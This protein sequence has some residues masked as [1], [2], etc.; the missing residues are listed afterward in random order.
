MKYAWIQKHRDLFPITT[1]CRVLEVSKSGF[2]KSLTAKPSKRALRTMRITD[3]VKRVFEDSDGI[4]GSYKVASSMN[5]GE[6]LENACRNTV[7]KIMRDLG[8]KIRVTKRFKPRTTVVDGLKKPAKNI[9][10]QNFV[11]SEP[12]LYWVADITYLRTKNGWIYLAAVLDLFSRKIVGWSIGE[13]MKAS[14]ICRALDQALQTRRPDTERLLHHSDRGCQYTSDEFQRMLADNGITCSMSST[15]CCY[16]NAV[17][18]R[19]FWSLKNEWTNHET[20]NDINDA[21]R[22]VFRYIETF[23]NTIRL[24]QTLGYKSPAQFEEFFEE[25]TAI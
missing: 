11:A 13:D 3:T 7:A 6:K 25:N 24:H 5:D 20:F 22:S 18:E 2:Y 8:M 12:N 16:D 1:M 4:Y 14:L 17:M 23:Y 15:G 19:F 21:R 9:L 10:D